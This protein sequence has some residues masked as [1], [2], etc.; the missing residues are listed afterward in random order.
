M[1]SLYKIWKMQKAMGGSELKRVCICVC[2]CVYIYIHTHI[3]IYK[4]N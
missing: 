4:E 3:Y 2:V 1:F